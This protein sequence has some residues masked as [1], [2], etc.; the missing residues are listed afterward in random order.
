MEIFAVEEG[1]KFS[2]K[3]RSYELLTLLYQHASLYYGEEIAVEEPL[4][5]RHLSQIVRAALPEEPEE[6]VSVVALSI[7]GDSS[8]ITY[9]QFLDRLTPSINS[10]EFELLESSSYSGNTSKTLDLTIRL[11]NVWIEMDYFERQLKG[12]L[13]AHSDLADRFL[14]EC[15][16]STMVVPQLVAEFLTKNKKVWPVLCSSRSRGSSNARSSS[17]RCWEGGSLSASSTAG[18]TAKPD[19]IKPSRSCRTT[20]STTITTSTDP[21]PNTL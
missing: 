2:L 1:L 11:F 19:S 16:E 6:G 14:E 13:Q 8:S 9:E 7:F 4:Q 12:I 5:L 3:F 15:T 18:W 20:T 21:H 10:R 17:G